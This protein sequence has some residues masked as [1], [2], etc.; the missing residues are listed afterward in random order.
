MSLSSTTVQAPTLCHAWKQG[1]GLCTLRTGHKGR[2]LDLLF[3][4][5]WPIGASDTAGKDGRR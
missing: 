3:N 5:S 2:H 1:T 4:H